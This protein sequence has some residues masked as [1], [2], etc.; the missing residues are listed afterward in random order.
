[1]GRRLALIL[2]LVVLAAELADGASASNSIDAINDTAWSGY[3]AHN[4]TFTDVKASWIQPA[5]DCS[6]LRQNTK[7]FAV[8]WAGLDGFSSNTVEQAGTELDCNGATPSYL[9]WYAFIPKTYVKLDQGTNPVQP[10]DQMSVEV[11]ASGGT[12]TI[13][14]TDTTQSWSISPQAPVGTDALSSAEW[15]VESLSTKLTDFGSVT[16]T[17]ATANSG[18]GDQAIDQG[19]WTTTRLTMVS[20]NGKNATAKDTIGSLSG[21]TSFTATWQHI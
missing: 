9:A 13:T 5:A 3:A 10:G 16:F 19:S 17:G 21:G 11:S 7:T 4:A 2:G 1:M 14:L 8:I 12:V 18:S 20:N 6:G 15:I